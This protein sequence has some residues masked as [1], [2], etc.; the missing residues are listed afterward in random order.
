VSDSGLDLDP[1]H[2]I[3]LSDTGDLLFLARLFAYQEALTGELRSTSSLTVAIMESGSSAQP[4]K[5]GTWTKL[6]IFVALYFLLFES[7]LEAVLALYLYGN[8]QVDSKMTLSVVLSLV[9]VCPAR[10]IIFCTFY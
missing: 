6:I 2:S 7:I 4:R 8:G 1:A 9:A 5:E 10:S 3:R